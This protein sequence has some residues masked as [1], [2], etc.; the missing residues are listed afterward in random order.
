MQED[1]GFEMTDQMKFGILGGLAVVAYHLLLYT[2]D[3]AFLFKPQLSW[4][5]LIIYVLFM[6]RSILAEKEQM[7]GPFTLRDGISAAFWVFVII[8]GLYHIFYYLLFNMIDPSL[9]EVQK[10]TIIDMEDQIRESLGDPYFE[11]LMESDFSVGLAN[12]FTAFCLT[13]I[14]GFLL[15]GLLALFFRRE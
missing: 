7:E 13:A 8:S 9:T 12:T 11:S 3:K 5:S 15:S 14:G 1:N 4:A 2:F 6:V 10:Q